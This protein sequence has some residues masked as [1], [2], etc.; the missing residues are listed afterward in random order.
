MFQL[1]IAL[2]SNT[3]ND[4]AVNVAPTPNVPL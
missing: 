3:P 1:R 4:D 2:D